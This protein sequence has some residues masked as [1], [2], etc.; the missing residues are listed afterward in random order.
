MAYACGGLSGPLLT[1][2]KVNDFFRWD[3][4]YSSKTILQQLPDQCM[5]SSALKV[6]V[7][8]TLSLE[9]A[10]AVELVPGALEADGRLDAAAAPLQVLGTLALLRL[11]RRVVA[12]GREQVMYPLGT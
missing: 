12:A 4:L 11:E 6:D 2:F 8:E 7:V 10:L 1:Y 9:L 5:R 3:F